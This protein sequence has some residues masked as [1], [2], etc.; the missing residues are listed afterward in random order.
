M[1]AARICYSKLRPGRRCRANCRTRSFLAR[2]FSRSWIIRSRRTWKRQKLCRVRRLLSNSSH[3]FHTAVSWRKAV[4]ECHSKETRGSYV[5][6]GAPITAGRERF[7][8][9]REG[10]LDLGPSVVTGMPGKSMG[11]EPVSELIGECGP[12]AGGR[13]R[14][15]MNP[16]AVRPRFRSQVALSEGSRCRKLANP[17][18][19]AVNSLASQVGFEPVTLRLTARDNCLFWAF[20]PMSPPN[21]GSRHGTVTWFSSNDTKSFDAMRTC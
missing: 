18:I 13:E 21:D 15:A 16:R 10:W 20:R 19:A 11:T 17:A 7:R 6:R 12:D 4:N 8:E 1:N 14:A 9:R 3:G 5:N 2:S